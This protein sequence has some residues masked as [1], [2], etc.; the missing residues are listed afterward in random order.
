MRRAMED[1][2]FNVLEPIMNVEITTS[3]ELVG[4]VLSDISRRRG[5]VRGVSEVGKQGVGS[6]RQVEADIP[7]EGL[8]GYSTAL[9]S[10]TKG[11]A[12]FSMAFKSYDVLP[13]DRVEQ[14]RKELYGLL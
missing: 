11:D 7:L 8:L 10:L 4:D 13:D 2:E 5:T 14:L 12:S 1:I 9:R 6:R 3:E